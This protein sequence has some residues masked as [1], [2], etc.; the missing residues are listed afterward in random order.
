MAFDGV[1]NYGCSIMRLLRAFGGVKTTSQSGEYELTGFPWPRGRF[2]N[3]PTLFRA[4][5]H[6]LSG[7]KVG[8][9]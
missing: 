5:V 1:D 2:K 8:G 6:S 3:E 4:M 9:V 7:W